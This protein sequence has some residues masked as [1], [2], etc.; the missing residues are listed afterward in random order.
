MCFQCFSL[1]GL[2]V[3]Y[4]KEYRRD[5]IYTEGK[6]V[7]AEH[8]IIY[9]MRNIEDTMTII[10]TDNNYTKIIILEEIQLMRAAK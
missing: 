4:I 6:S 9:E 3:W 7:F 5:L 2:Y 8:I 1:H 10:H